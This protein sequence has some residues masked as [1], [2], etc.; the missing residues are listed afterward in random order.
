M[1]GRLVGKVAIITGAGS[2]IG[3]ATAQRFA[4]E[5]ASVVVNDIGSSMA[6]DGTDTQIADEVVEEIRA[7]GGSG[8]AS[9][10]SVDTPEGGEVI[11]R[12]AVDQLGR[13]DAVVSNAGIFHT[14]PFED[15][16]HDEWRRMLRV[17]LDG[18]F[19]LSQPAYRVMKEQGYGRFVFIAS[20]AG[21][22]G[23]PN[24]AHYAAAKAGT[25]EGP[26]RAGAGE[27][28][29]AAGGGAAGRGRGASKAA[30]T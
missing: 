4:A 18:A 24:S 17:H 15:L 5:G 29:A 7:G 8:V 3:R 9:Y 11:V 25:I 22:F 30:V 12:T 16:T 21:L 27:G 14:A 10:D 2:G 6:V 19:H 23:Q 26:S 13:L 20:S 1:A 28:A